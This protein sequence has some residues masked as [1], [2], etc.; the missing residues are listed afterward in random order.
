MQC[1]DRTGHEDAIIICVRLPTVLADM[2]IPP[3]KVHSDEPLCR[4]GGVECHDLAAALASV[5]QRGIVKGL[6][7]PKAFEARRNG[8][9]AN[10][11]SVGMPIKLKR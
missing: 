1:A 6:A 2:L 3:A 8:E 4:G 9:L 5:S 10:R 11:P 7:E